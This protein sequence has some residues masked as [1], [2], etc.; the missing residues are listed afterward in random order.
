MKIIIANW[1][2]KLGL[3]ASRRLAADYARELENSPAAVVVCPS[4]FALAAVAE[5]IAGSNLK[6]GAQNCFWLEP[7]AYTGEVA[8]ETLAELGC[9]YV[10][11][12]H[13]ER[14]QYAGESDQV[15][16]LKLAA[17]LSRGQDLVPVL[18]VGESASEHTAG[19]SA[20]WVRQQLVACLRGLDFGRQQIIVAYEPLWAIGTGLAIQP[21][22]AAVTHQLIKNEVSALL[23]C[24]PDK[25]AVLYGGSVD[26][27]NAAALGTVSDGLLVGGASL[28]IA[29]FKA[30]I[31]NIG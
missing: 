20:D 16:N 6:L 2:M 27:S 31:S 11:C 4:E 25:V 10:L 15:V 23:K 30:I 8:V 1:K 5:A 21:A 12:G 24:P 18:C 9:R 22:E 29:E 26:G 14:R 19:H 17:L 7:G 28:E 3:A 13:S